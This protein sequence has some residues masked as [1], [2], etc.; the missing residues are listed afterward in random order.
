MQLPEPTATVVDIT[1]RGVVVPEAPIPEAPLVLVDLLT[2]AGVTG[3]AYLFAYARWALEPLVRCVD[4]LAAHLRG[5]PLDPPAMNRTIA[6]V[7]RLIEPTGL[8]GLAAGGLDMVAWDAAARVAGAPLVEFLG[9][10]R[11]AI[12]TYS[13]GGFWWWTEPHDLVTEA[14]AALDAGFGAMKLRLGRPDVADDV[15]AARAVRR[16]LDDDVAVMSDFNQMLAVA[17]APARLAA[18][19]AEGLLWFEDPVP[20]DDLPTYARLRELLATDVQGGENFGSAAV[21]AQAFA[22]GALDRVMP[23]VQRLGVTGWLAVADHAATAGIPVSTHMFPEFSAHLLPLAAT[24]DWLEFMDLA[25][26]IR[27]EP[28]VVADGATAAPDRPGAGIEW[29]DEA[30]DARRVV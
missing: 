9:G 2:D 23:D 18:L 7:T 4:G 1:A 30:V 21:A 12:P 25:A 17:D 24:S 29:D 27:R 19:D 20:H 14:H 13:S 15:A 5:L 16:A 6:S 10:E 22:A 8:V 26:A 28:L 11:R 3:R